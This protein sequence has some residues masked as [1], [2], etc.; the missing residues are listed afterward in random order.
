MLEETVNEAREPRNYRG[1]PN[2][3]TVAVGDTVHVHS[4]ISRP[5]LNERNGTVVRAA[6]PVTGRVGVL[7]EGETQPLN[8]KKA[9]LSLPGQTNV[10]ELSYHIGLPPDE[11]SVMGTP[12][13]TS[14]QILRHFRASHTPSLRL[15]VQDSTWTAFSSRHLVE[16]GTLFRQNLYEYSHDVQSEAV[17]VELVP[18]RGNVPPQLENRVFTHTAQ[19]VPF[20]MKRVLYE[21]NV[22]EPRWA[23]LFAQAAT[24][25]RLVLN[26][27]EMVGVCSGDQ[28]EELLKPAFAAAGFRKAA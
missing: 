11:D 28:I 15:D 10:R 6:D 2:W 23:D 25:L 19:G 24:P 27:G 14:E 20:V 21:I 26:V 1:I 17:R 8:L 18:R 12:L 4:I 9:N 5:A 7:V 16:G 22:S 13:T 3:L